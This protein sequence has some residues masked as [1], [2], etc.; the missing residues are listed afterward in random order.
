MC[1]PYAGPGAVQGLACRIK[2]T[3]RCRRRAIPQARLHV[4][5]KKLPSADGAGRGRKATKGPE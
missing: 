3:F 2:E 4:G 5:V 1:K